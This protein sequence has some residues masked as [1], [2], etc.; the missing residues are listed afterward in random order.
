MR[1]GHDQGALV[2]VRIG[3]F[4]LETHETWFVGCL[5]LWITFFPLDMVSR[6][7]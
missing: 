7:G 1:A 4:V 6:S 3:A 5:F 2:E